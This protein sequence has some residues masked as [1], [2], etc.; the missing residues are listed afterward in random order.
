MAQP[1][2][3]SQVITDEVGSWPGVEIDREELGEVGFAVSGRQLGHLHGDHTVHLSL[4]RQAWHELRAEGRI[5]PHP[6]FP[7]SPGW[8]QRRIANEADVQD[9]IELLRISYERVVARRGEPATGAAAR[10]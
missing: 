6:V 5:E 8:A 1:R 10:S 4:G 3:A 2:T 7:N 9:A